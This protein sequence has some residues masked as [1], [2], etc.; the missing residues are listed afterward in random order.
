MPSYET[1]EDAVRALASVTRYAQWRATPGGR[2]V[3]PSGLDVRGARAL[4]AQTLAGES[5]AVLDED[6]LR[7]LLACYG[8]E[9]WQQPMVH[10]PDDA[11]AAASEL[12]WPVALKATAPHLR[13]R[14]ELGGV[15]LDLAGQQ[16]LRAAYAALRDR[17]GSDTG[18]LVVQRMA[19]VGVATRIAAIQDPLIG[20]VV[21]F[22]LGGAATDL[23][24]DRAHG[25]PPLSDRDLAALVR[26]V[27]AAPLLLGHRGGPAAD[28]PAL[29]DLIAR[30]GRLVDDVP[31]VASVVLNPVVAGAVGAAVLAA[32]GRLARP[33]LPLDR[34][35]RSLPG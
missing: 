20:P 17:H 6:T 22:G 9:V 31:E 28:L 27:R 10:S 33:D 8:I 14:R 2:A 15:Y 5:T 7:Q 16:E 30:I 29:E 12:G 1:P 3:S 32:R 24:D 11:V 34:P 21:S 25:V 26:G 13:H 19:P 35:A 4:V 18:P 23:L